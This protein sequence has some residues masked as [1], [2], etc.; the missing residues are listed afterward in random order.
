[1]WTRKELKQKAKEAL[2]RNYWKAVLIS[3]LLLIIDGGFNPATAAGGGN[4]TD[5]SRNEI[6]ESTYEIISEIGADN[7]SRTIVSSVLDRLI[8]IDPVVIAAAAVAIFAFVLIVIA[9]IMAIE[10]LLI[11]PL[12][13][14]VQ[15]FML[16]CVEDK[17][18]IAEVGYAFDHSYLNCVKAMFFREMYIFL[19]A[20]LF[21][22]P[23]IYKKYQYYMVEYILAMNPEMPY[24]EVLELSTRMMAGH[25][26]N[27][28]VLDLSFILW[29]ILG[30]VTCGIAE[31]LYVQPYAQLTRASLYYELCSDY[32]KNNEYV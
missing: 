32:A 13:I 28:F 5:S 24:K 19:W 4:N 12:I 6:Q 9:V 25:K 14:G 17:G 26:W 10:I 8:Q 27:T 21:V 31:V 3:L 23:G 1:M 16:K 11:N 15:R 7:V 30:V 22:I 2:K 20:L 18:N 29:H